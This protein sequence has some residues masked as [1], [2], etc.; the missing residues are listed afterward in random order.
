MS[1]SLQSIQAFTAIRAEGI[2]RIVPRQGG[3]VYSNKSVLYHTRS[4]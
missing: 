2:S 4:Q 3:E 1:T